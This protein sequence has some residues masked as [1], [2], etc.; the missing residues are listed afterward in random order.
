M[1]SLVQV[2]G[3][4]L[5]PAIGGVLH[6]IYSASARPC[7]II[8]SSVFL[9]REDLMLQ[10]SYS[11]TAEFITWW[12]LSLSQQRVLD[13]HFAVLWKV[14]LREDPSSRGILRLPKACICY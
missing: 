4:T 5:W 1:Q 10:H 2:E 14:K 9:V 3:M 12:I 11:N 7:H 8:I 13:L 6:C